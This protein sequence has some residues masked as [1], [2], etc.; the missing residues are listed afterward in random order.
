MTPLF[1]INQEIKNGNINVIYGAGNTGMDLFVEL[2]NRDIYVD[3]FCDSSP[4]KWGILLMNKKVLSID[5]LITLKGKCNI[6]IASIFFNEINEELERIGF[7]NIYNYR[8]NWRIN[9]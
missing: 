5:E 4:Q 3:Y 7:E 6:F 9:M 1:L 2:I 8:N